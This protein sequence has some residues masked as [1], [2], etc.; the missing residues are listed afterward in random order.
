[1]NIS[2]FQYRIR[3]NKHVDRELFSELVARFVAGHP[4][5]FVY[6]SMG[7]GH[8]LDHSAIYRRCG[9]RN[10]YSFDKKP[11][12]VRRARFN[13]PVQ[14]MVCRAHT[15]GELLSRFDEIPPLFSAERVIVWLDYQ[16]ARQRHVQLIEFMELLGRL[17]VGD[18]ARITLDLDTTAL[19]N[20]IDSVD[21][22]KGD[23]AQRLA[24]ALR[25][26]LGAQFFPFGIDRVTKLCLPEVISAAIET[27]CDRASTGS[28][29]FVPL[30][31]TTYQDTSR[32]LTVAVEV[33]GE[34]GGSQLPNWGFRPRGSSDI[35]RIETPVLSPRERYAIES[36]LE[37]SPSSIVEE[38]EFA[39]PDW[40][41]YISCY[42]RLQRFQPRLQETLE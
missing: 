41:D 18:L 32:M 36:M 22:N 25:E 11:E 9:L 19:E 40:T 29:R 10:L 37:C 3:P 31:R 33:V 27:A 30:L 4:E 21:E 12:V 2:G 8:V 20:R 42:Q 1:M 24:G 39:T 16:G 14:G 6:I 7:A 13:R 34:R 23:K 5:D 15:S 28:K 35:I 17:K 38:L 26:N